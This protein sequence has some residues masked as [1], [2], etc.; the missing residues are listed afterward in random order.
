MNDHIVLTYQFEK[1]SDKLGILS[2][3]VSNA[4]PHDVY[5]V[6]PLTEFRDGR[7]QA[8]SSR[9]YVYWDEIHNVHLTKRIWA[10]PED[11]DVYLPEVPMLTKLPS[12][13]IFEEQVQ[14]PLPLKINFPYQFAADAGDNITRYPVQKMSQDLVFSIGYVSLERIDLVNQLKRVDG[15]TYFS[16]PYGAIIE[17]QQIVIGKKIFVTVGVSDL[18][19]D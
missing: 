16:L 18:Q 10:V 9:V 7:V 13:K 5:L 14:L 19:R 11:I 2:Y 17:N 8:L 6:T 3:R 4:S 15:Q 12:G 1:Q